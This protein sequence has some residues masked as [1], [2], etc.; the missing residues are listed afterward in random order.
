VG[1]VVLLAAFANVIIGLYLGQVDWYWYLIVGLV[2]LLIWITGG[3]KSFYDRRA[4]RHD[5]KRRA[6]GAEPQHGSEAQFLSGGGP[7]DA[8]R[9]RT[10]MA[11]RN[12]E[13]LL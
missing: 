10:E 4:V 12:K 9:R 5:P 11:P 8:G 6:L 1:R 2:W 7:D 3:A 13:F